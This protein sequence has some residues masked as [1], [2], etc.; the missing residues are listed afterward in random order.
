MTGQPAP[1][2][3][4][5]S[6]DLTTG[7]QKPATAAFTPE[8]WQVDEATA[9]YLPNEQLRVGWVDE[10]KFHEVCTIADIENDWGHARLIAAAPDMYEALKLIRSIIVEGART[11]FNPHSGDWAERLYASQAISLAA[12]AKAE[13]KQ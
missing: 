7:D 1:L 11:G 10:G 4:P 8:P 12:L 9:Y 3:A 6:G 2:V 5:A 13:G